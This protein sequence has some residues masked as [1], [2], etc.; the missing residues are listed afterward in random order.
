MVEDVDGIQ[1][2]S[3]SMLLLPRSSEPASIDEKDY[4]TKYN[5]RWRQTLYLV[6]LF[7]K[8]WLKLYIPTLQLTQRW[9]DPK[10]NLK[11]GDLVLMI[12]SARSRWQWP[13]AVV[14]DIQEGTDG[15]VRKVTLRTAN[16]IVRRDVRQ[17]C[18]LE[19]EV[20]ESQNPEQLE[21]SRDSSTSGG[22]VGFSCNGCTTHE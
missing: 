8:R 16:G 2:L 10:P 9:H 15:L 14:T 20:E 19:G 6:D 3:P 11:V 7:W 17:L 4:T 12:E 18:K 21:T 1:A 13:K 22:N 5:R